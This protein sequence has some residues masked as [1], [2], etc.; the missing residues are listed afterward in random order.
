MSNLN[1][2]QMKDTERFEARIRARYGRKKE[3]GYSGAR[4]QQAL[5]PYELGAM[6]SGIDPRNSTTA[7]SVEHN[8]PKKVTRKGKT[9]PMTNGMSQGGTMTTAIGM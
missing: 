9:V 1:N 8:K 7:R 5:M 2:K 3:S 6:G 4:Y